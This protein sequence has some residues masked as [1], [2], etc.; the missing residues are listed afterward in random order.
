M[1]GSVVLSHLDCS[2]TNNVSMQMLNEAFDR[3][4]YHFKKGEKLNPSL[5]ASERG[6]DKGVVRLHVA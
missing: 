1:K 5:S 4:G 6:R 3:L 2:M